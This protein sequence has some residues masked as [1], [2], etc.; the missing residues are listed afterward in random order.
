MATICGPN[1]SFIASFFWKLWPKNLQNW[2]Q[3]GQVPKKKRGFRK[4]KS[5]TANTQKLKPFD[6]QTMEE[7]GCYRLCENLC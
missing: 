7:C 3:L 6:P 5:R 1:F 4:V 2:A